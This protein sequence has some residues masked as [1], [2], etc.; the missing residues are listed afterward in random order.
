MISEVTLVGVVSNVLKFQFC[1]LDLCTHS[2]NRRV[3][4]L[5]SP[6]NVVST[7]PVC[8]VGRSHGEKVNV[9]W[10]KERRERGMGPTV[11]KAT[12]APMALSI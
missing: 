3:G 9:R 10:A 4:A 8:A 5:P 11:K 2:A 1:L 12:V 7:F 6:P